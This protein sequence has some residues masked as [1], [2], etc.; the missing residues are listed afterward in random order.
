MPSSVRQVDF[1]LNQRLRDVV[2]RRLLCDVCQLCN[3]PF[4]RVRKAIQMDGDRRKELFRNRAS[5][6][7]FALVIGEARCP[8]LQL[9]IV[10]LTCVHLERHKARWR[11]RS[12]RGTSD[13]ARPPQDPSDSDDARHPA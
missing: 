1:D 8:P 5:S 12:T 2:K 6:S 4:T 11:Q 7:P 13:F 9:F 10:R 3:Q